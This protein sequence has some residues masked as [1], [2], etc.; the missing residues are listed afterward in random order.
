MS[1]KVLVIAFVLMAVAMLATPMV[2]TVMAGKGQTKQYYEFYLEGAGAPDENTKM[3]TTD[4]GILQ[5]RNYP[6]YA[7]YIEVTVRGTTYYPDPASYIGTMDFTLD[8]NTMHITIRVHETFAVAGGT[9]TQDTAEMI[10]GF[11]TPDMAGGGSFVGFGSGALAGVKIV[12]KTT[13][14]TGLDRVGT[15]MGWP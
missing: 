12:G 10:T 8:T 4:G 7:T 11:G 2:A 5:A 13:T 1:K 14:T 3:W 9:I 6:Y 15:V